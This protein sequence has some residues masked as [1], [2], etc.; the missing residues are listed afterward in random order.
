MDCF[1]A[2]LSGEVRL[3]VR[4]CGPPRVGRVPRCLSFELGGSGAS[5][6]AF[7]VSRLAPGRRCEGS[8]NRDGE[9]G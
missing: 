4:R 9:A 6:L 8:A 3:W 1:W 5:F 2:A 7:V